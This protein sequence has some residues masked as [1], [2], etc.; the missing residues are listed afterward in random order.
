MGNHGKMW[1]FH[2]MKIADLCKLASGY[3][4]ISNL[5]MTI[6]IVDCPVRHGDFP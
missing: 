5:K 2:G 3:V 1:V 4:K 6:E